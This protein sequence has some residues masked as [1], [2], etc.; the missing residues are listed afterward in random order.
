[1]GLT[2]LLLATFHA[3]MRPC[4]FLKLHTTHH[5][6]YLGS[7]SQAILYF[8]SSYPAGGS[9]LRATARR[10][11]AALHARA[12]KICEATGLQGSTNSSSG[13]YF[14]HFLSPI[15]LT[16]V[17]ICFR[18]EIYYMNWSK[19]W[20]WGFM[21]QAKSSQECCNLQSAVQCNHSRD[22]QSQIP[23]FSH[24]GPHQQT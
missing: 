3:M 16:L 9:S 24:S 4:S 23:Q 8:S 13:L 19:L 1:M 7:W 22:P 17:G 21:F 12:M 6:A 2:Y 5:Y 15:Y 10:S 11:L 14:D 18:M 20:Q